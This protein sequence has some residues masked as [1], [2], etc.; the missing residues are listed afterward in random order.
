[1]NGRYNGV[2]IQTP[3]EQDD[4]DP[5]LDGK[6]SDGKAIVEIAAVRLS[7]KVL[8]F[9]V[10]SDFALNL[11]RL[12]HFISKMVQNEGGRGVPNANMTAEAARDLVGSD[13]RL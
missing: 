5:S 7:P 12:G 3:G 1:M 10:P 4:A 6:R 2:S 13:L 8:N 11:L 9:E